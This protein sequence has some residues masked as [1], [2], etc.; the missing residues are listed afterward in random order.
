MDFWTKYQ[1]Q[2]RSTAIYPRQENNLLYPTL[3]LMGEIGEVSNKLKK[4]IR[5]NNYSTGL[6]DEI[7]DVCW[8]MANFCCELQINLSDLFEDLGNY[9]QAKENN[10]Y[11][12]MLAIQVSL[13]IISGNVLSLINSECGSMRSTKDNIFAN[14]HNIVIGLNN[15]CNFLNLDLKDIAKNNIEKLLDRK[16]RDVLRGSGDNR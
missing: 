11:E 12:E 9:N 10:I 15:M 5:D 7:G 14:L 1:E 4:N 2:A 13:G 16:Q 8:Y 3:G 6:P